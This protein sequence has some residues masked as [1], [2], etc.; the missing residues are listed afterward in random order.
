MS[1]IYMKILL[2]TS[3]LND[4][5]PFPFGSSFTLGPISILYFFDNWAIISWLDEGEG[6]LKPYASWILG[7]ISYMFWCLWL[8]RNE[9]RICNCQ[10]IASS[11]V[12]EA[13]A[14]FNEAFPSIPIVEG[15]KTLNLLL[16][17]SKF[18]LILY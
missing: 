18:D 10:A 16:E 17:V 2:P 5:W 11:L 9:V 12:Y 15:S 1:T 6:F 14:M 8:N 7:R 4:L 13:L 3:Y